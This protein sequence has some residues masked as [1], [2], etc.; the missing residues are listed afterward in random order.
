MWSKVRKASRRQVASKGL[1]SMSAQAPG[2]G[3]AAGPLQQSAS[4]TAGRPAHWE[5]LCG[6]TAVTGRGWGD[7][8][9]GRGDTMPHGGT[10]LHPATGHT[11]GNGRARSNNRG[12]EQQREQAD[13]AAAHLCSQQDN[14]QQQNGG[15]SPS[16]H[17]QTTDER[18]VA[19]PCN[20]IGRT[21]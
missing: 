11:R 10:E 14:S 21:S 12:S 2:G 9:A 19:N 4:E 5:E 6:S 3:A 13:L 20:G 16:V 7:A 15:S 17:R 1:Q 8:G 18:N